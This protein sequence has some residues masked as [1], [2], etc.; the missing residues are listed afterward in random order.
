MHTVTV[1]ILGSVAVGGGIRWE[2]RRLV[3]FAVTT[4]IVLAVSL[5]GLR[6]LFA[7]ALRQPFSGAELVY[8]MQPRLGGPPAA[9]ERD[10]PARTAPAAGGVLENIR[11]RGVLRVLT[12]P[13]RLPFAFENREGRLVG[14]DVELAQALA[15]DLGVDVKF[16]RA[17]STE[18][19]RLLADGVCDIAMSGVVL[20]PERAADVLFSMPYF[21]ETLAFVV[22]DQLRDRFRTWEDIRQLG[23]VRVGVPDL[24]AFVRAV[25][26]RAPN[27]QIV[28]LRQTS[29]ILTGRDEVMAYV[30]PAERGSVLT[31]LQPAYSVIVPQPDTIKLPL[32]YPLAGGDERWASY[33]NTWLQL[34]RGDGSIDMLYRH[35]ILGEN[36]APR[37]ARWSVARNVLH[38]VK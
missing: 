18:M 33:V 28:R 15:T 36:A 21:D 2:L 30:L 26:T 38:W 24:P 8:S 12:L 5:I 14:L 13:D 25:A 34:K 6:V 3:R 29:E 35:W 27:L 1:A 32:A 23:T 4:G 17:E 7:T 37:P 11:A 20:S 19:K 22:R 31:L 16:F 10:L 9:L